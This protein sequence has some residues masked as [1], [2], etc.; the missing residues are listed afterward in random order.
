[1]TS[2]NAWLNTQTKSGTGLIN[3]TNYKP[4][5]LGSAGMVKPTSVG[6]AGVVKQSIPSTPKT[7]GI[8]TN[9]TTTN[10]NVGNSVNTG[11]NYYNSLQSLPEYNGFDWNFQMPSTP[12]NPVVTQEMI[13]DWIKRAQEE[14]GLTFDPQLLSI[15][16]ELQTALLSADQSKGSIPKYYQDIIDAINQWQTK[17]TSAEQQRQ[18][19]RGFGNSGTL[20]A[21]E[22][23]LAKEA[24]KQTTAAETEKA[25]KLSNID[26]Q[27]QLLTTQAGQKKTQIETNR[28]QYISARQAELQDSYTAN[29]QALE[30]QKFANQMQIQQVGL[31]AESQAF[32]DWLDRMSLANEIN[33]QNQ[34]LGLEQLSAEIAANAKSESSQSKSALGNYL[35]NNSGSTLASRK[36]Y[37]NSSNPTTSYQDQLAEYAAKKALEDLMNGA[38]SEPLKPLGVTLAQAQAKKNQAAQATQ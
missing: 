35:S 8:V 30:Q 26:E 15:E 6:N 31:T 7:N 19:A 29:Q 24:L 38:W 21:Q 25:Q 16:Q 17:E 3:K 12:Q 5:N 18:Y 22:N 14:A 36:S 10:T 11:G 32:S 20:L 37:Q 13:N 34:V 2:L 27:K 9:P 23:E 1:M 33:Y 28:G 4:T